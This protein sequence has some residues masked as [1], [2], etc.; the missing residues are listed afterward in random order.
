M[1]G[2]VLLI[3]AV[4]AYKYINQAKI[5]NEIAELNDL[6]VATIRYG[7]SVGD[8]TSTNVTIPVLAQMNFFPASNVSG[9]GTNTAVKNQWGGAVTV[10]GTNATDY[11]KLIY[12]GMPIDVCRDLAIKLDNTVAKITSSDGTTTTVKAVGAKASVANAI[13][14]CGNT[15]NSATLMYWFSR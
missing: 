8:F 15:E 11:I 6:K 5:N 1:V 4:G 10:S 7:Q 12:A 2:V 3:G 9:T 14:A 13:T